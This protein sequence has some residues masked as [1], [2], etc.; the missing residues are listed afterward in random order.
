MRVFVFAL[1]LI[2]AACDLQDS[3]PAENAETLTLIEVIQL[4]IPEPSGLSFDG[5]DGFLYCVNDPPNNRVYQLSTA[6]LT[7][8]ILSFQGN[9]LEGVY[10]EEGGQYL[11][12]VEEGLGELIRLTK[13]GE[14]LERL[15]SNYDV[16]ISNSGFEG[17]TRTWSNADFMVINE[18]SPVHIIHLDSTGTSIAVHAVDFATDLS[19][20]CQGRQTDEYFLIS[21]QDQ[22]LYEWSWSTGVIAEYRFEIEQAE[23][24]A[25]DSVQEIIYIVCDATS[26]L[27]RYQLTEG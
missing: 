21:D 15:T 27:Y 2:I 16:A 3:L 20:I 5:S 12:V 10:V 1:I 25:Y 4:D 14:E 6:G 26:N 22:S 24:V 19:G 13:D 7:S 9:D 8:R 23:G 17:L 18:K 11:W